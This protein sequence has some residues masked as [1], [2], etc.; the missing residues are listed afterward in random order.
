MFPASAYLEGR[1]I[2]ID[3]PIHWTSHDVVNK[4]RNRL[5]RYCQVKKL[6]VG[7][8]GTLDPLATGLLILATGKYTKHL[9]TLI[10]QSKEYTGSLRLGAVT[11]SYDAETEVSGYFPTAHIT[12]EMIYATAK[13][14]EG[15]IEQVPPAHSAVKVAGKPMYIHARKGMDLQAA[16]RAVEI[17]AFEITGIE[18][19]LV[20]FRVE[21]SKG[22]Y[23]RTLASDFGKALNSGAY[24][25]SL[26]RTRIGEY[27]IEN[28]ST[29]QD[30]LQTLELNQR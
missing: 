6:K 26:R 16:A 15:N 14:F 9:E 23:I 24:L 22:T 19:P 29:L 7:H 25:T 13:Q 4:V 12:P 17:S 11:E 3:K 8:A 21:C 27:A 2:L 20:H 10:T 18:M 28:A 30:F 5:T 1:L